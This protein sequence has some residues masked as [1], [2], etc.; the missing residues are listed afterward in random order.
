MRRFLILLVTLVAWDATAAPVLDQSSTDF[1]SSSYVYNGVSM[2]QTFTPSISG[3]L[4]DLMLFSSQGQPSSQPIFMSIDSTSQGMPNQVLGNLS[5]Q[6]TDQSWTWYDLNFANQN[7]QLTSGTLYA[8]VISS[9]GLGGIANP[10]GSVEDHYSG[11]MSLVQNGAG[12]AW[13]PYARAVDLDFQT[14]M[15]AEVPEPSCVLI[16]LAGLGLTLLSR[17]SVK[18]LTINGKRVS[19]TKSS[20]E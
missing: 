15:I 7:I 5:F 2:A 18:T 20:F 9:D 16:I 1:S 17:L 12:T 8:L 3:A 4:S 19:S 14:Y 13:E 10:A 11:G 6:I